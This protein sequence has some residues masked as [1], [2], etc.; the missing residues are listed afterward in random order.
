MLMMMARRRVLEQQSPGVEG[1]GDIEL[2]A[3]P[4]PE[5]LAPEDLAARTVYGEARG[6]PA[7][8]QAVAA[9][10][11]NRLAFMRRARP[12][13]SMADVAL[14]PRQL[15]AWNPGDPNRAEML[16][17]PE[18][19][20]V[21]S[22]IRGMVAGMMARRLADPTGGATMYHNVGGRPAWDWSAL[23]PER[24]PPTAGPETTIAVTKS[25]RSSS[26]SR[27]PN[28]AT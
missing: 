28:S 3:P 12:A 1:L 11:L 13:A 21:L 19:D 7:S 15:S 18:E 24:W 5:A 9:V 23:A 25:T 8:Q 22:G 27:A 2:P 6:D 26:A 4:G 14:A 20:P 10:L 17:V 16:A